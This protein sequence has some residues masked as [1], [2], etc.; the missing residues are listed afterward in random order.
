MKSE[1]WEK[2]WGSDEE[3]EYWKIPAPEVIEFI[4]EVKDEF[5]QSSVLDLGC[6]VGRHAIAFAQ[7]GFYVHAVDFSEE[8]L[9]Q[10]N[11]ISIKNNLQ[12]ETREGDYRF[13]L[14]EDDS[15]DI[16]LSY[17]VLYHGSRNEFR[18]S[19]NKCYDYLKPNGLL[20]FTCLTREDDKYGSGK[21]VGPHSYLS[22]NSVHPGDIH[23][24]S[25]ESDLMEMLEAFEVKSLSRNEH[26]WNHKGEKR[27]SSYWIVKARKR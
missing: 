17:N 12:I 6:G 2:Y 9:N 13:K 19:L 5:H 7:E 23:Y 15:F 8:A 21:Q 3:L 11:T 14:Y 4:D 20:M 25:S 24:F 10:L 18:E 1:S 27:F 22:E 26:E 16:I